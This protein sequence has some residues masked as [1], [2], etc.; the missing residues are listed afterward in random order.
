[1]K[2]LV[3]IPSYA[4]ADVESKIAAD[5][6]PK[7]DYQALCDALGGHNGETDDS[8]E[9]LDY[10]SVDRARHPAVQLAYRLAGKDAA[11]ALLGFLRRNHFD[12]I[13]TNAEKIA[14]PLS[15]LLRTVDERPRHVTI[16]H[17]LTAKKKQGFYR[18]LKLFLQMDA[19]FVYSSAQ[20][21]FACATLGIPKSRVRLIPF[22]ADHRFYRPLGGVHEQEDQI[23]AAGLEWRDYPTLIRAVSG[24]SNLRVLLAAASPWSK[25]RSDL[26]TS[27]L[28]AHVS[29][30]SYEYEELR[31]LYAQSSFV[32]VPLYQNDFQ[33]GITTIL[34]AMAMGK[35]VIVTGTLGQTDVVIH[36]ENGL[37]VAPGDIE[38][39][40]AAIERLHGDRELRFRLGQAARKWVEE[41]A[42]LD[43]WVGDIVAGMRP[44]RSNGVARKVGGTES[45]QSSAPES[46]FSAALSS[47][48]T[49]LVPHLHTAPTSAGS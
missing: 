12:T 17:R 15:M 13:F 22:H 40:R 27:E 39:L 14:L 11:L 31:T 37:Y 26:D 35:P 49:P 18:W 20:Y 33:A 48:V 6:H 43:R 34:E 36:E 45:A 21:E 30:C 10:A 32:V 41:R 28:P 46:A 4:K 5:R 44:T 3:M 1:M 7:M 19:I 8:V 2:A 9:L 24:L 25:H 47:M 16:A 29:A 42:T 23:C 38:G